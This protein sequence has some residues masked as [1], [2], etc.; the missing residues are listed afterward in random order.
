MRP[1]A[2]W[3]HKLSSAERSY[4]ATEREL[5]AIVR[6]VQHWRAYLHGSPHPILLQSDCN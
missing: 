2:F 6:A 4:S 5:M 1:V 3:S